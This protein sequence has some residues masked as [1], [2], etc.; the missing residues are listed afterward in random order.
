MQKKQWCQKCVFVTM[1]GF[2]ENVLYRRATKRKL[3]PSY[4]AEKENK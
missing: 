2:F 4:N 1:G 3:S